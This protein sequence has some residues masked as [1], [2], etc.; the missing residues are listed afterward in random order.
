[1]ALKVGGKWLLGEVAKLSGKNDEA[2]A[3]EVDNIRDELLADL[4]KRV[5]A[6]KEELAA[7][8]QQVAQLDAAQAAKLIDDFVAGALTSG[9]TKR[10][11]LLA[12]AAAQFDS[13]LHPTDVRFYLRCVHEMH[14]DQIELLL[15]AHASGTARLSVDVRAAK[16]AMLEA[17]AGAWPTFIQRSPSGPYVLTQAG[18]ALCAIIEPAK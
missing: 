17:L 8:K 13:R 18:K 1:M 15:E 5:D 2:V 12:L 3:E 6:L 4:R 16:W 9:P 10:K 14:D 11:A 7:V